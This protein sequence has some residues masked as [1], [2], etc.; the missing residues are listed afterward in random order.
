MQK[1]YSFY[2]KIAFPYLNSFQGA[3][4]QSA[5][6]DP[7]IYNWNGNPIQILEKSYDWF[8]WKLGKSSQHYKN[9]C[10]LNKVSLI[11]PKLNPA[12]SFENQSEISFLRQG[13]RY[14]LMSFFPLRYPCFNWF[15]SLLF[16]SYDLFLCLL[17]I[18]SNKNYIFT[19][20]WSYIWFL[21]W[22]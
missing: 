19:L 20:L 2:Q 21:S 22:F 9:F 13:V 16:S 12:F 11:L 6:C 15:S 5:K 4:I 3:L 1:I 18:L 8:W 7:S 10:F 14:Y 17:P